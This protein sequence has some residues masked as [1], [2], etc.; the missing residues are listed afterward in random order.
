M[1]NGIFSFDQIQTE[2]TNY[3][4]LAV[5]PQGGNTGLV[6]ASIPVFDEIILSL[7][8]MNEIE[9]FDETSGTL[10]C[11]A[12]CILEQLDNYVGNLGYIVPLDLG[13][14]GRQDPSHISLIRR[15]I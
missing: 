7:S 12:G 8:L 4:S 6:G 13:A 1:K 15:P 3:F 5:V 9:S 14:K 10:Q 2:I 11:Q